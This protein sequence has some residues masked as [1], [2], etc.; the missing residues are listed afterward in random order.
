MDNYYITV[1]VVSS[2]SINAIMHRKTIYTTIRG[3]TRQVFRYSKQ[4]N[5]LIENT[6]LLQE[7]LLDP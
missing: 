3:N 6:D 2:L 7:A 1:D 4:D 5:R